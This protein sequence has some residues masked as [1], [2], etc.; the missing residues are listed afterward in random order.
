M[1]LICV[2]H[3]RHTHM[4]LIYDNHMYVITGRRAYTRLELNRIYVDTAREF[5]AALESLLEYADSK[6]GSDK[7]HWEPMK[8]GYLNPKGQLTHVQPETDSDGDGG[9]AA[10][11]RG[12]GFIE[13]SQKCLPHGSLH[14]PEKLMW[15]GH[16][17]MHDTCAP[18]AS[19]RIY[20]KK[21]MDRVRKLSDEETSSSMIEWVYR[22]HTWAK[23][24]RAVEKDYLQQSGK[25]RRSNKPK[26]KIKA[27]V[28]FPASK[29]H[30]P[31]HILIHGLRGD[32]FSPL[33][34]GKDHLLTPDVRVS[35]N[36]VSSTI[37]FTHVIHTYDYHM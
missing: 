19:H 1:T 13:F 27:C 9:S 11:L 23:I 31:N 35:Y 14:F 22:T 28:N 37:L 21:A 24:I 34:A 3:I 18:E 16:F 25:Q 10:I 29:I 7:K 17:Y 26:R 32:S 33:R 30:K 6:L 4:L 15:A 8:K 2:Y 12:R 36:E 20:I 5:F